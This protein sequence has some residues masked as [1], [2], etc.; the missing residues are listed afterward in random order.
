M[1]LSCFVRFSS[2]GAFCHVSFGRFTNGSRGEASSHLI[3]HHK[4]SYT[5]TVCVDCMCDY[6]ACDFL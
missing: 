4:T 6:L 2:S 1:W 3:L 5:T